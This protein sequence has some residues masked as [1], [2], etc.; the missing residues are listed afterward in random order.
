MLPPIDLRYNPNIVTLSCRLVAPALSVAHADT[1]RFLTGAVPSPRRSRGNP[2][3]T[4]RF[5]TC[6]VSKD[7]TRTTRNQQESAVKRTV[8]GTGIYAGL[9]RLVLISAIAGPAMAQPSALPSKSEDL[10]P[11]ASPQAET[12]A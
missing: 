12:R 8:K 5:E 3:L 2:S 7:A 10:K 9:T 6:G 11:S 1:V 4:P